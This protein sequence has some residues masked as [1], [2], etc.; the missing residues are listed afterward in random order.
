MMARQYY[1]Y[2]L[3]TLWTGSIITI[4][5]PLYVLEKGGR[6][7]RGER[8][9]VKNERQKEKTETDRQTETER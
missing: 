5:W 8:H 9:T 4:I 3:A 2:D 1:N 7:G 6:E